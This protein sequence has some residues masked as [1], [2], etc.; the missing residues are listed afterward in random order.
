[1]FEL[2]LRTSLSKGPAETMIRPKL[3][4]QYTFSSASMTE[5]GF[6]VISYVAV[7]LIMRMAQPYLNCKEL[8]VSCISSKHLSYVNSSANKQGQR[9]PALKSNMI[10]MGNRTNQTNCSRSSNTPYQG[11]LQCAFEPC[12]YFLSSPPSNDDSGLDPAKCE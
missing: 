6:K 11:H 8:W 7:V 3:Y 5:V 10:A 9:I 12:Q 4:Q 2:T 1:M